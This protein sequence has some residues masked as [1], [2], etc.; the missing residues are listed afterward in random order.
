MYNDTPAEDMGLTA[1]NDNVPDLPLA[2]VNVSA[3]P[4]IYQV[5]SDHLGRP[6]RMTDGTR[7]TVWQA[8]WKPW[9]E[10]Q[11]ITGSQANNLRFPGQYFQLETG[12][13]YNWHRH[14]D[15]VTGRYIQ[16]DPLRFVDGPSIYAYARS[17]PYMNVD[18]E[19]R[20]AFAIPIVVQLS[21]IVVNGLSAVAGFIAGVALGE[22]VNDAVANQPDS[23]P[24]P[25]PVPESSDPPKYTPRPQSST[26]AP[27]I[28]R[29]LP[30][31]GG[32]C[33][34]TCRAGDANQGGYLGFVMVEAV[35]PTCAQAAQQAC[36]AAINRCEV[37]HQ[38]HATAKCSDKTQR[39]PS[40]AVH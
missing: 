6:I 1:A 17:S 39:S 31:G 22:A 24:N 7:A 3:T 18:R 10:P 14:Y 19:G 13:A 36:K 26:K 35:A 28:E 34:C 11:S 33:A 8:T 21:P 29:P 30:P 9:G 16:P 32:M 37:S 27:D 38:H 5:H 4:V 23:S 40:G 15:P 2:V 25:L 20:V 12:L